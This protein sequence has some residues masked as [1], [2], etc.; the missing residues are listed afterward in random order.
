MLKTFEQFII[1]SDN[2][3]TFNIKSRSSFFAINEGQ[4]SKS[5]SQA[6]KLYMKVKNCDYGE[7]DYLRR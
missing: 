5:R 7:G 4:E 6:K 1:G 2:N 3:S